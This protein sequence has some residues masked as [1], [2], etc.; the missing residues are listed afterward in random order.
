MSIELQFKDLVQETIGGGFEPD[1]VTR[2]A[3]FV[4]DL[5]CDSLD[6]IELIMAAEEKWD[7]EIRDQDVEL[8]RTV[9]QAC[10]YIKSRLYPGTKKPE[11]AHV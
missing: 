10:D 8:I 6:F 7:I 11:V 1:E 3:D 4:N 5:G 2:D 9:G